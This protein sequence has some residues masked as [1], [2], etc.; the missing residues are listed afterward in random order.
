VDQLWAEAV[1]CW[2]LGEPLYLAGDPAKFA[3][4]EQEEHREH[5]GREGLISDYVEK[6]VPAE[7]PK[8]DLQQRLVWL[9]GG[10]QG[11]GNLVDR[12]R[13]CALEVWCEC[14][15]GD[16]KGMKYADAAEINSVIMAM[17]GWKRTKGGARFGYAGYQRGFTKAETSNVSA[18]FQVSGD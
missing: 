5:S 18:M 7:W 9:G 16:A 1:L 12:D 11:T 6:K 3:E 4:A 10:C 17:P 15:K 2:R 8:W 14:L 13:I